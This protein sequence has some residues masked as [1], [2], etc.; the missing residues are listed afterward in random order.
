MIDPSASPFD[1]LIG[2]EW[3]EMTAERGAATLEVADHHMQPYGVVHGG[4][5][6]T[7]A[8]GVASRATHFA[9]GDEELISMGQSNHTTFLR[10]ITGGTIHV[11]AHRRHAGRTTWIWD[12]EVADDDERLCALARVIVAVRPRQR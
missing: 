1:D 2:T 12:V 3:G 10:P 9:L 8:E 6:A 11:V 7:L 4:V 5:L